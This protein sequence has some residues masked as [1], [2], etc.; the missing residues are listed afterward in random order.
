MPEP[1]PK[2]KKVGRPKLAKGSAKAEMLRVRA[3]PDELKAFDR[4]AKASK[5]KR[6]EWIRETLNAAAQG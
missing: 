6:S 4:A 5:Q 2:P 3:T 1:K